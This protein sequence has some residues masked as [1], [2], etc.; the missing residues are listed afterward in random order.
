ML[1]LQPSV[2]KPSHEYTREELIDIC[3]R[4]IVPVEK[5]GNR[6]SPGAHEK[7]GLCLVMLKAGC[8]FHVTYHGDK[9]DP[10]I[11]NDSTIWLYVFWPS[12]GTIE[13]GGAESEE[14]FYL[15]TPQRLEQRKGRDWY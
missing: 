10:C 13:Y 4:A 8:R 7:L 2:V 11:T 12:F 15:P 1:H 14:H 6:D 5:W 3:E 9:N